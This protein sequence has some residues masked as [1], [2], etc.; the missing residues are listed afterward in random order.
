MEPLLRQ[1][2]E[3]ERRLQ[4]LEAAKVV[5]NNFAATGAPGSGDD[6]DDG[7]SVGSVWINVSADDAY[8][9][10]DATASAAVWKKTTP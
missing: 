1:I 7:Y 9:C 2:K 10:V 6:S 5:K 8:V 4:R 3:L